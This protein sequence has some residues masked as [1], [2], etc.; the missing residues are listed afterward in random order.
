MKLYG[1]WR[2]SCSYRVRL[3]LAVKGIDYEYAAIP[4]REGVQK[5]AEYVSK[6]PYRNLPSV[7][8][9]MEASE[10]RAIDLG[11]EPKVEAVRNALA[12]ARQVISDGADAP[13]F[14]MLVGRTMDILRE[15]TRPRLR[16]VINA[17]G[18]MI[19]TNLGRA[20]LMVD[21]TV[22]SHGYSNLE[23]DL[24]T[25]KRGSR[26]THLEEL[27]CDLCGAESALVVKFR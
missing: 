4:L 2:S 10:L 11:H 12:H 1:Y 26:R 23:F 3:A 24:V 6:N 22:S 8:A 16:N 21:E 14:E 25:G 13:T 7:D 17:T 27:I 9:L 20:P 15:F 5:S 19:H 18:V